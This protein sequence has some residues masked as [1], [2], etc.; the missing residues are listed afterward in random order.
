[1]PYVPTVATA[2]A[3]I[4]TT[5]KNRNA[6]ISMRR[7]RR[8]PSE[9]RSAFSPIGPPP[10]MR[11]ILHLKRSRF[12][13]EFFDKYGSGPLAGPLPQISKRAGWPDRSTVPSRLHAKHDGIAGRCAA[14]GEAERAAYACPNRSPGER[15]ISS[16]F[17]RCAPLHRESDL[18]RRPCAHGAMKRDRRP[19]GRRFEGHAMKARAQLLALSTVTA[20]R[21]CD[22]Q[23][24][25]SH[26]ATG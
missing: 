11:E 5:V 16:G 9:G 6:K 24:M 13:A 17:L 1:M 3:G 22:Q 4:N 18:S 10:A 26:T 8:R 7:R 19:L 12:Q 25:S 15:I 14:R 2:S 23:E 20:R 21:F